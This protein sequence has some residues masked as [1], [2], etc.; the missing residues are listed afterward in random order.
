MKV[1]HDITALRQWRRQLTGPLGFVPTMGNLHAGHLSLV[2]L[3]Q[4]HAQHVAVSIFVNP[5]QFG[6]GEDFDRYPRT[7]AAD[8]EQLESVG[9]GLLFAPDAATLFPIPQTCHIE[10]PPLAQDL[11]GRSRP[12]H[13]RGVATIVMKLL[14]LLQPDIACFGKKDYQQLTLIRLMAEAFN[15]PIEILGG[16]TLRAD[17]GLA[18]SSRNQYLSAGQREQAAQLYATLTSVAA[19]VQRHGLHDLTRLENEAEAALATAGWQPDY[20]RVRDRRLDPPQAATR[21]LVVLGAA[22]LGE[23]RLIDNLEFIVTTPG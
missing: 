1:I 20:I 14:Q 9:T 15:V 7:L 4:Q 13:F 22:R 10:L 18:L 6:A 11:C 17:D 5:L 21:D 8:I 16:E 23:T 19:Q 2:R 3:A 12:G